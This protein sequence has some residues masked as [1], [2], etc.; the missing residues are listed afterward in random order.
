MTHRIS[1]AALAE[2]IVVFDK[3]KIVEEGNH[4]ELLA[5]DGRY[6][7]LYSEQARWYNR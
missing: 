3:G 2:R 6:A 4:Q 5:Q 7:A 1:V